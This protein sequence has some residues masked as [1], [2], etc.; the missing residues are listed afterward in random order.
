MAKSRVL[1]LCVV[2]ALAFTAPAAAE[3]EGQ[4]SPDSA[5]TLT[6]F[7]ESPGCDGPDGV[8]GPFA[9]TAGDLPRSEAIL[10][11][12]GD[13]Y[14]RTIGD[15]RD[16][17][18]AMQLPMGSHPATVYVHER[19]APALQLV[20][21]NLRAEEARGNYY[22][23][24]WWDTWSYRA[25]TVPPNRHLSF[26]AV[27]AAID[28][29]STTN[30][31]R[32]DNVLITDMP[33]WF[34]RA[35]TDAGWCWGGDW[36]TIKDPMHF[37]WQGPLLT[38]D[39]NEPQPIPPSTASAN[40][41]RAVTFTTGAG[42][43]PDDAVDLVVD[44][45]RDGAPD[46]VR[47]SPWTLSGNVGIEACKA[48]HG[49]ETCWTSSATARPPSDGAT[50]L[51]ADGTANGRPDL[52][53]IRDSGDYLQI[54]L[55][56]YAS[57]Y[58]Q[59]QR[60][61]T[62]SIPSAAGAEYL[63]A[64]HNRDGHA[65]LYVIVPGNPTTVDVWRGPNL[66]RRIVAATIP[67][68]ADG[69]WQ[70]AL[71]KR[72]ADAIPDL[73]VLSPDQPARLT[74]FSGNSGFAGS[75]ETVTTTISGHD[76]TMQ[77]GDLDGDGRDDLYFYDSNGSLTVYL[78]GDR[79]S[80]PRADLIYWFYEGH[81]PHWTFGSGCPENVD[82]VAGTVQV[83]AGGGASAALYYNPITRRWIVAGSMPQYWQRNLRYEGIDLETFVIGGQTV[84]AA[85]EDRGS[86][87]RVRLFAYTGLGVGGVAFGAIANPEDLLSTEIGG[88][89][90]LGILYDD[91]SGN[92]VLVFRDVHSRRLGRINLPAFDGT[93]AT[94]LGDVDGD[95]AVDFAVL[96]VGESGPAVRVVALDGTLLSEAGL[97]TAMTV[98]D[99]TALAGPEDQGPRYALLLHDAAN[100][101]TQVWIMDA[102]T[103]T[104]V[105]VQQVPTS[106]EVAM[107][108]MGEDVVVAYRRRGSGAVHVRMLDTATGERNFRR[109]SAVDFGPESL[110]YSPDTGL[111]IGGR[112]V[113]DGAVQVDLRNNVGKLRWRTQYLM[114]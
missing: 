109:R 84:F 67:V 58:S 74:T 21:D 15:V 94:P 39:Y 88:T 42:T 86:R 9:T 64:D 113:S 61:T 73:F 79:G 62:V 89:P 34:V 40:F 90:A 29:N 68:A 8:R 19:V 96:G 7:N 100:G 30:P 50:L 48:M 25:A 49:F 10:G 108:T 69:T 46:A 4:P 91:R 106:Y 101:Q 77:T 44:I 2:V 95:G 99:L 85:A 45:D 3:D 82:N 32:R 27:G 102:A 18:V 1:A 76:G 11:P 36:Q 110:V 87:T 66:N 114:S 112:R 16:N 6:S 17:L 59:R 107:T 41:E 65:D 56:T 13:F 111:V 43:A 12:W 5:L 23:I 63:V 103:G 47:V 105:T 57:N 26:H 38:P 31:Y 20:I 24:R 71:G 55:H 33:D 78:G 104:P 54:F 52:W 70:F 37:S 53:E 81:N 80:T 60:L 28:I 83:A 51:L 75:G 93:E 98:S 92:S 97:A 22:E 72:D 14:G 35:W